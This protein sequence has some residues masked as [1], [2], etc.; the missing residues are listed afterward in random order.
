MVVLKNFSAQWRLFL[1]L[2]MVGLS[3]TLAV[4]SVKVTGND[5]AVADDGLSGQCG[6]LRESDDCG[7]Y[8]WWFVL[9]TLPVSFT[10]CALLLSSAASKPHSIVLVR[11]F[12]PL[13]WGSRVTLSWLLFCWLFVESLWHLLQP[14]AL[15]FNIAQGILTFVYLAIFCR[16][17]LRQAFV[18]GTERLSAPDRRHRW[19][20]FWSGTGATLLLVILEM[21]PV[22]LSAD[23][24][25]AFYAGT[26]EVVYVI[27]S[28]PDIVVDLF[29][30]AWLVRG[31]WLPA[32]TVP[33][34]TSLSPVSGTLKDSARSMLL[35]WGLCSGVFVIQFLVFSAGWELAEQSPN[36]MVGPIVL[37]LDYMYWLT[38]V[39]IAGIWVRTAAGI[40]NIAYWHAAT[41][42]GYEV[43]V[44]FWTWFHAFYDGTVT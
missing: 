6:L 26:Y 18:D 3:F 32:R 40:G 11:V 4:F 24:R 44:M 14:L 15:V 5:T 39:I 2:E 43:M 37:L 25:V 12:Q 29:L 19:R 13:S 31:I 8:G 20:L 17:E 1:V 35:G 36:T 22:W 33:T 21:V 23:A 30:Y 27:L 28:L 34:S 16:Q 42:L 41:L 38:W 9:F 7:I 10:L